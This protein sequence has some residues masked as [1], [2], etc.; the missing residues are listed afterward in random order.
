MPHTVEQ[1]L[2]EYTSRLLG[3]A[4]LDQTDYYA[5]PGTGSQAHRDRSSG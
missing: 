1:V 4:G 2:E 5:Y 3:F